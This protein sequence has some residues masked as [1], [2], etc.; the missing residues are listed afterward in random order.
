MELGYKLREIKFRAW[1]LPQYEGDEAYMGEVREWRINEGG[2]Y[3]W[4]CVEKG[5]EKGWQPRVTGS[6]NRKDDVIILQFTGLCDKNGKEIYEGDIVKRIW[7]E[8]GSEGM[9]EIVKDIRSLEHIR[10]GSNWEIEVGGGYYGQ[11]IESFKLKEDIIGRLETDLESA[12]E[13]TDLTKRIEFILNL[14]NGWIIDEVKDSKYELQE[15]DRD[16]II[17]GNLEHYKRVQREDLDFYS[18]RNYKGIRGIV[19]KNGDKWKIIDGY[20]RISKSENRK[21][22]DLV[23]N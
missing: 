8:D 10:A 15:V 21:V 5:N 6:N 2:T 18:D 16:D 7:I 12:F 4:N 23:C 3:T 13:I 20:H 9:T 17:F 22:K 14:E 1:C 11:E 19:K